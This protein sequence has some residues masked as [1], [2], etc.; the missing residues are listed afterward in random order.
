MAVMVSTDEQIQQDVL[1][2]EAERAAWSAPGVSSVENRT[3][4]SLRAL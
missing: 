1:R 3:V 4:V 2:E